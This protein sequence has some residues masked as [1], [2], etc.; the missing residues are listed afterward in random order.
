MVLIG[1][2]ALLWAIGVTGMSTTPLLSN[3][4][5]GGIFVMGLEEQLVEV[6]EAH[7]AGTVDDTA[8]ALEGVTLPVD[9]G[10][11]RATP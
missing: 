7:A 2:R 11:R 9:D 1:V 6:E 3:V 10:V 5:S 4:S 8:A